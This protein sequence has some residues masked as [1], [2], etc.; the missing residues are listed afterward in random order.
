VSTWISTAVRCSVVALPLVV[1]CSPLPG[2]TLDPLYLKGPNAPAPAQGKPS[3]SAVQA[4]PA[5]AVSA[6]V[7]PASIAATHW[8]GRYQDSRGTGDMTVELVRGTSIV[9]GT[10]KLRTG[11]GGPLTAIGDDR[12]GQALDLRME[13]VGQ[14]C[15]G[16]FQG[17]LR[18]T[19]AT[20]VATYRGTDCQGPVSDGRLE[21]HRSE[22][23][24][25]R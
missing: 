23:V 21:L 3:A 18:L 17:S 5:A 6:P 15:P 12:L 24:A 4:K 25:P 13:S 7:A 11:G 8:M 16:T 19:E 1:A 14:D 22:G 2:A 9:S 20:A 10:W